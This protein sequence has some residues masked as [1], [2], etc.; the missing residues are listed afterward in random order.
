[1]LKYLYFSIKHLIKRQKMSTTQ[2]NK[3]L[4]IIGSSHIAKQSLEEVKAVITAEKPAIIAVE[5]DR[6]RFQALTSKEKPSKIG[7]KDAFKLGMTTYLF[8]SIG[9]WAQKHLGGVV[10]VEPGSEMKAAIKI[11]KKQNIRVAL[12]DQD[13]EITFKRLSKALTRKEKWNFIKDIL[14]AFIPIKT[15]ETKKLEKE[16]MFDLSKVPEKELINKMIKLMKGRYPSI[17]KVL[18]DERNKVMADNLIRIMKDNP[19]K[20]IVAVVGAGHEEGLKKLL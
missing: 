8:A 17:Y 14:S 2:V 9:S 3:N 15:K 11:A 16:L 5:L 6:K 20:K 10:G 18:I 7:I 12:I 1:M 19:D 4:V 13:I